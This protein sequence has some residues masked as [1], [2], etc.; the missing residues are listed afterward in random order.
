MDREVKSIFF[1]I[2]KITDDELKSELKNRILELEKQSPRYRAYAKPADLS[3]WNT[4]KLMNEIAQSAL[5]DNANLEIFKKSSEWAE[6]VGDDKDYNYK[7]SDYVECLLNTKDEPYYTI[8]SIL[9]DYYAL[10]LP[11]YYAE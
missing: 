3:G 6:Y 1:N 4:Q 5:D 8:S 7:F 10:E 2:D 11:Y 9:F